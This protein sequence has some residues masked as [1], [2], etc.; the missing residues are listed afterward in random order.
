MC[1]CVPLAAERSLWRVRTRLSSHRGRE[2]R[3]GAPDGRVVT[4][5]RGGP[6]ESRQARETGECKRCSACGGAKQPSDAARAR[7]RFRACY[8]R[9]LLDAGTPAPNSAQSVDP[10]FFQSARSHSRPRRGVPRASIA[11]T[12]ACVASAIHCVRMKASALC[13]TTAK[14]GPAYAASTT[15]YLRLEPERKPRGR[16]TATRVW[17]SPTW[18]I[19]AA[20]GISRTVAPSSDRTNQRGIAVRDASRL[21]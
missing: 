11:T 9:M 5:T 6:D 21:T 7:A 4:A 19:P 2:G 12:T 8:V 10:H 16:T 15:A 20:V 13:W 17:S 14:P 18:V 1:S 3:D